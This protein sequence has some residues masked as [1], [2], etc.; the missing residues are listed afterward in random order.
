MAH[1]HTLEN[2]E[3]IIRDD[4]SK[5]DVQSVAECMEVELTPEQVTQVMDIVVEAFDANE[6]INWDSFEMAIEMVLGEQNVNAR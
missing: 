1:I 5:E 4:W 3:V 6:G 2:G